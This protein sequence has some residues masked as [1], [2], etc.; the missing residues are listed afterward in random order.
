MAKYS[1]I[2]VEAVADADT[3][4]N[5]EVT[6]PETGAEL[7]MK[8][9]S[10]Q[11]FIDSADKWAAFYGKL[12][13]AV[14]AAPSLDYKSMLK[15]YTADEYLQV[16]AKRRGVRGDTTRCPSWPTVPASRISFV[17]PAN[18]MENHGHGHAHHSHDD[19]AH[20]GK[21][22]SS[23]CGGDDQEHKHE[24]SHDHGHDHGHSHPSPAHAPAVKA[25]S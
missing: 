1:W 22:G 15:K 3:T 2:D 19:H 6:V 18:T 10:D 23:C 21:E 17:S 16:L 24:E 11:G 5:L 25:S 9:K 13:A 7:H 12:D 20:D 4:G 8:V 14:A